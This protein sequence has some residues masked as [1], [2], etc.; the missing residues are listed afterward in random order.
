[1]ERSVWTKSAYSSIGHHLTT[2]SPFGEGAESMVSQYG[3]APP[4]KPRKLPPAN[5]P[6]LLEIIGGAN[7]PL[8][9][10]EVCPM[11]PQAVAARGLQLCEPRSYTGKSRVGE[12]PLILKES[13]R[14]KVN[15][16][17]GSIS[18]SQPTRTQLKSKH[19]KCC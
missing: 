5:A 11:I 6:P 13:R 18:P 16:T 3:A 17:T 9:R 19:S 12:Q 7:R 8:P 10:A 4:T 14:G 15:A 1:M 2:A